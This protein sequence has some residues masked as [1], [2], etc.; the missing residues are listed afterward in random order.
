MLLT[1][2][3]ELD[4]IEKT[5]F[6]KKSQVALIWEQFRKNKLAVLGL[7]LLGIMLLGAIFAGFIC[8]YEQDAVGQNIR[9]RLQR[10]SLNHWFGTDQYGRDMF[11]RVLFGTR[12]S[13]T[14]GLA[15]I[16][17]SLIVG[18]IIGAIC[19]FYGGA[20]DG[21]LMRI[22][23]ILL[24][25]P[26]SLMAIAI[27]AALGSSIFNMMLAL[28][29]ATVPQFSRIVRSTVLGIRQLDYIEAAK[30]CASSDARIIFKHIIPNAVGPI[31]VHATVSM[32]RTILLIST[33]GFLGIGVPAPTPE[34]G[35]I[36]AENRGNMRYYPFTVIIPGI[37]IMIAVLSL[38]LIGDGLR[39]SLDPKLKS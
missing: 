36:L 39:D 1:R 29:I 12:I 15:V 27:V 23:D 30:A 26:A 18:S 7:V 6:K 14:I 31:I 32:A 38:N 20:V 34:W 21:F 10:P 13:L 4:N 9:N 35:T 16:L 24:A 8:D 28:S 2:N 33:L 19:G 11:A 25:I 17:F 37:A 5:T 3:I 22:M